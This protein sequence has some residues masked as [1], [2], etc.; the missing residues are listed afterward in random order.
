MKQSNRFGNPLK[1]K[2]NDFRYGTIS[3]DEMINWL[4]KKL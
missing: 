3:M 1:E 4:K 2:L